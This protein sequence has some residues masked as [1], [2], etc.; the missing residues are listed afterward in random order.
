MTRQG[1]HKKTT[2]TDVG[3]WCFRRAM[4]LLGGLVMCYFLPDFLAIFLP[5]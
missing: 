5:P 2:L 3:G 4:R 1:P